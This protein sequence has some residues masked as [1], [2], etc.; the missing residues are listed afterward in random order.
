MATERFSL[1][2]LLLWWPLTMD[3]D[4]DDDG[5]DSI[6]LYISMALNSALHLIRKTHSNDSNGVQIKETGLKSVC[7]F[8]L[9]QAT[10]FL[11][12]TLT[13]ALSILWSS[14]LTPGSW[15]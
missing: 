8:W 14:G 13:K 11:T 15:W 6:S 7:Q 4:D 3:D 2:L 12:R 1:L 10:S 9:L 5:I